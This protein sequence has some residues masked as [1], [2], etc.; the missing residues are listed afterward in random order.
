MSSEA[1][2]SR[3]EWEIELD[4]FDAKVFR[5]RRGR[6]TLTRIEFTDDV[7]VYLTVGDESLAIKGDDLRDLNE[8][9]KVK[10]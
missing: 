8:I 4:G 6:V 3:V 10:I 2:T 9:L 1:K 7:E 5:V